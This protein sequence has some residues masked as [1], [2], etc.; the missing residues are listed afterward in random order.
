MGSTTRQVANGHVSLRRALLGPFTT[1]SLGAAAIHFAVT[2]AHFQEWWAFGLF[3]AAIGWFQ[4][5]WPIAYLLMPGARTAGL[6]VLV[7]LDILAT[8]FEL[9]LVLGLVAVAIGPVRRRTLEQRVATS[10]S[11]A[12]AATLALAVVLST[13]AAIAMG[14]Q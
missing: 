6:A 12:W 2:S 1:L 13:S 4:A 5:L 9:L 7:N 10:T 3:L 8:L 11:F 14:M